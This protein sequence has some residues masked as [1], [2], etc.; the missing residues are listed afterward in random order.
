[1]IS[2]RE[3]VCLLQY[4]S[5]CV[6]ILLSTSIAVGDFGVWVHSRWLPS[7]WCLL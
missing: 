5:L 7:A 6:D 4:L 1:M 2:I 3:E